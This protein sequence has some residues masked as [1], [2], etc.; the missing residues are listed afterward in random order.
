MSFSR[1]LKVKSWLENI[2]NEIES[3]EAVFSNNLISHEDIGETRRAGIIGH[4]QDLE[5]LIDDILFDMEN[6][7]NKNEETG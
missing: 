1:R 3:I 5:M 2:G 4:L 6:K 7:E